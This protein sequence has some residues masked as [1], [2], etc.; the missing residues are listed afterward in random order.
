[1]NYE[2]N[3][4]GGGCP[5]QAGGDMRA[6]HAFAERMEGVKVRERSESFA[7][8]FS[9]AT[10]FWN[11]QSDAEKDHI[12]SAAHF[13][14]GKVDH[15]HIRQRI[16][17]LFFHVDRELAERAAAGLGVTEVTGDLAYLEQST[18]PRPNDVRGAAAPGVAPSLSME[19]TPKGSVR[20]RKVM[21]SAADGFDDPSFEAVRRVLQEAGAKPMVVAEMLGTLTGESG[22]TVEVDKSHITTGSIEFDAVLVSGGERCVE[23]LRLQGDAIHAVREAFKHC[24]PL[25]AMGAAVQLFAE[26]G[27][28]G[29]ELADVDGDRI[30]TDQGVVT[31]GRG[32]DPVA[33]ADALLQAIGQHRH[34]ARQRASV[35]A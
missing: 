8:H 14:L 9:Q 13:E 30:V 4:L 29:I 31:A 15:M 16:C 26:A 21:I 24:K 2:P 10:L 5:M 27:L 17:D 19:G 7:D 11:S 20:T 12:V 22:S 18:A 33:F 35:P 1:V 6:L 34:W 32:A 23:T 3:S 28:P 25:A